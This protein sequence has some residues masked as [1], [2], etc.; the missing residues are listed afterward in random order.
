MLGESQGSQQPH[1]NCPI[2]TPIFI[3]IMDMVDFLSN[4]IHQKCC[5]CPQ[6]KTVGNDSCVPQGT[7]CV[8]KEKTVGRDYTKQQMLP[9][10]YCFS[11]WLCSL[12]P[13]PPSLATHPQP[14]RAESLKEWTSQRQSLTGRRW[15]SNANNSLNF[16]GQNKSEINLYKFY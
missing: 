14:T 5:I 2:V 3:T 10:W 7:L 12:L 9:L 15:T 16:S 13:V 11:H 1:L 8:R 4:W 6:E